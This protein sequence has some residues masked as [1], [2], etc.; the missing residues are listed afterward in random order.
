MPEEGDLRRS[1]AQ[2]SVGQDHEA[3]ASADLRPSVPGRRVTGAA[4]QQKRGKDG[5][6]QRVVFDQMGGPEVLRIVEEADPVP[7]AG[8]VLVDL[9]SIGLNRA[10]VAFRSGKYLI[11][12]SL[13]CG[14]GVEG[15]GVVA[16]IGPD[17][18]GFAVGDRVCILPAFP[19]GG[20][21]ASYV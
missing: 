12:P 1:A 10:D 18:E 3:G 5:V 14:L 21:Y 13:P 7:G 8:E 20:R 19:Q 16:D 6:A 15:A 4:S 9:R 11:Q 2:E 17:V